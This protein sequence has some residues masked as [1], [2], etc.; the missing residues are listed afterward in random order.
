MLGEASNG[1]ITMTSGACYADLDSFKSTLISISGNLKYC[2]FLGGGGGQAVGGK[3]QT[4]TETL[5]NE[6][7]LCKYTFLL[8]KIT[9]IQASL[10]AVSQNHQLKISSK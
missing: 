4:Q 6:D 5:T 8:Q 9:S 3:R 1:E 2:C 7:F 10:S